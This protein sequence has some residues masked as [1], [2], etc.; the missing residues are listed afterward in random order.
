[1]QSFEFFLSCDLNQEKTRVKFTNVQ[2][3]H[4]ISAA[5]EPERDDGRRF[6][7]LGDSRRCPI[8]VAAAVVQHTYGPS[9]SEGTRT[10]AEQILG[11]ST[12]AQRFEDRVGGSGAV[13]QDLV[14]LGRLGPDAVFEDHDVAVGTDGWIIRVIGR[15]EVVGG[16]EM[17]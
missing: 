16:R 8:P 6:P 10:A 14:V 15:G 9:T 17:G 12:A 1:M 4:R 11:E 3:V 5:I 2:P 13:D 7:G